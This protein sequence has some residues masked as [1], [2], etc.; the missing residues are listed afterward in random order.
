MNGV[1]DEGRVRGSGPVR[2]EGDAEDDALRRREPPAGERP[3]VGLCAALEQARWGAWDQPADLLPRMYVEAVQRAGGAALLLPVDESWIADPGVVLDRLDALI[4]AGGIDVDPSVYGAERDPRTG[5]TLPDRDRCEI[6]LVRAALARD[7]PL[8]GICRGMQVMN[9]AVGGTLTQHVPEWAAARGADA[10]ASHLR[11][12]GSF[13]DADHSV[14]TAADSLAE[15][16]AGGSRATVKS[17]HH[18]A[19]DRLGDG[20]V[21]TAWSLTDDLPEAIESPGRRF[22]LGVQWHPEAAADDRVIPA[23]VDAARRRTG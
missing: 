15:R 17:H 2:G 18:Q 6:A 11:T 5:P 10:V 19:V 3:V 7:M 20:M 4:V 9:V 13:A 1:A 22:A 12:P 21:V 23:L 8:L 14:R 16:A